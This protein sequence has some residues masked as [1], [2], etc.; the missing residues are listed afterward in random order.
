[1]R[2][3]DF[4]ID[5]IIPAAVY[6]G[7]DSAS[8]RNEYQE[9]SWGVEGGQRVRLTTSPPSVWRLSRKCGTLDVSQA[10][11]H[12]RPAKGIAL[13]F[14]FYL[15]PF[16][17][18]RM[19]ERSETYGILKLPFNLVELCNVNNTA[20]RSRVKR[21]RLTFILQICTSILSR[22]QS[23]L[24]LLATGLSTSNWLSGQYL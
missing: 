14:T 23:L 8:N 19:G 9:S 24:K 5:L 16:T 4:S 20:L 17:M 2:S 12:S 13:P 22:I 18:E 7:V 21:L 15:L 11:G 1:M 3:L 6:P 10:Y